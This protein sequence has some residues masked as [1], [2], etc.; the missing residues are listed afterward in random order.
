[1]LRSIIKAL[2]SYSNSSL[3]AL[4]SKALGIE[5]YFRI[6]KEVITYFKSYMVEFTKEEFTYIFGGIF[7][8]GGNSDMLKLMDE[9]TH[10]TMETSPG[11]SLTMYDVSHAD[12]YYNMGDDNIGSLYDD[13]LFRLK[14]AYKNIKN[15]G[16]EIWYDN[17]KRITR[18][19]SF[20]IDDDTEVI[21]N[22]VSN[23][24][25]YKIII[26][27]ENVDNGY[28]PGYYGNVL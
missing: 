16:Y 8:N 4:E 20:D 21:A 25:S 24:S 9:I 27:I 23:G 1:M 6:L 5:E 18:N 12:T 28:P 22:V 19:P 17:G 14:A 2:E 15:T 26:N 10:G 7:D 13:A 11:D 3:A